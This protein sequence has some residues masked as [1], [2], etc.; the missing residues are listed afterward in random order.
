MRATVTAPGHVE[1]QPHPFLIDATIAAPCMMLV[2]K[3]CPAKAPRCRAAVQD[4]AM[5][6]DCKGRASSD[7]HLATRPAPGPA[8]DEKTIDA[9]VDQIAAGGA[10]AALTQTPIPPGRA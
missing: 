5:R 9:R 7:T 8:E 2:A 3:P 1:E 6:V 10:A 4:G